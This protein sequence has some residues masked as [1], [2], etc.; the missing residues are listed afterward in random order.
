QG[1]PHG[2]AVLDLG[3]DHQG[4]PVAPAPGHQHVP[5]GGDAALGA[6]QLGVTVG[7]WGEGAGDAAPVDDPDGVAVDAVAGEAHDLGHGWA[8]VGQRAQGAVAELVAAGP[9]GPHL[10]DQRDRQQRL[11][12]AGDAH[13]AGL[14]LV[15]Y[16]V[17][18]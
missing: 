9:G 5:L 3:H 12:R 13:G 4:A 17:Y 11:V 1:D 2:L 15:L 16:G 8:D 14:G 10:L 6:P 18:G 7:A